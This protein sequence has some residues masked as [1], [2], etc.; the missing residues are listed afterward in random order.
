MK[1][2]VHTATVEG[3]SEY[4]GRVTAKTRTLDVGPPPEFDGSDDWWSPEEL[5]V[6]AVASCLWTTFK[7]MARRDRLQVDGF[8]ARGEATL[9]KGPTGWTVTGVHLEVHVESP[10]PVRALDVL[11]RSER[12]C[13][14][15]GA[16][17]APVTVAADAVSSPAA[18]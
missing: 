1:T 11:R 18:A 17:K 4:P 16:L 6:G 8:R 3:G 12:Y 7:A 13:L 9:E 2:Q 15:S 14:V 5:L 10:E